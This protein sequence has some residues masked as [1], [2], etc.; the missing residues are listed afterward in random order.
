[1]QEPQSATTEPVKAMSLSE[2]LAGIFASPGEV[3]ENVRLTPQ[4]NSNWLVP[5]LLLIVVTLILS[6]LTISNPTLVDQMT[7]IQRDA[8]EK[9]VEEGRMTQE[10]ADAQ[11]E[12]MGP[13]SPFL[14]IGIL[15]G[16]PIFTFIRLFFL[17]LV[18]WVM[19]K[20]AMKATA[21]YLK[22]TEVVGLTLY[23]GIVEVLVTTGLAF[24]MNNLFA[25]PSLA[26]L[27]SDFD[28]NDKLHLVLAK[29]NIF[30]LWTIVVTGIG[31]SKLF[32][33][34]LPKVLVLVFALWV[35]YCAITILAG[36]RLG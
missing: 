33:R 6:Y 34:D 31:L 10:Q 21:P 17:A 32:Q 29:V 8:I 18:F 22:V 4:T 14:L 11:M 35:L 13:G 36:I 15:V 28:I 7:A 20:T 24:G 12:R 9:M 1:M 30:T 19:G 3:F 16:P 23:I 2:K 25:S 26:L 27:V 5:T